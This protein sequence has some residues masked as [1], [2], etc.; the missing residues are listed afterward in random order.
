MAA[1]Q[2][3]QFKPMVPAPR[4]CMR[5]GNAA[6]IPTVT[7]SPNATRSATARPGRS[8]W[9]RTWA[10][11]SGTSGWAGTGSIQAYRR[12]LREERTDHGAEYVMFYIWG[13]DH[14]RSLLRCRHAAHIP[15]LESMPRRRM[16]HGNFWPH[17]EMDLETGR[18][19]EKE[20]PLSTPSSLYQMTDPQFMVEHL[21]DDLALQLCRF[22]AWAT[23][24]TWTRRT[25]SKLAA[26]LGL[27]LGL[28]PGIEPC[29][30]GDRTPRQIFNARHPVRPGKDAGVRPAEREEIDDCSV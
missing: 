8:I 29:S 15:D 16:F 5:A 23:S 28:E 13:D 12:M 27:S 19:V 2:F 22:Q 18:L 9:R 17:L 20:N 10:S 21:K 14:I 25:I 6:S 1:R 4:L 11:P 24:G 30:T 26:R 3:P 7:A